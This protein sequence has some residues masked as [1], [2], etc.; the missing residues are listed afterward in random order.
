MAE[1]LGPG[2]NIRLYESPAGFDIPGLIADLPF[3]IREHGPSIVCRLFPEISRD[4][5]VRLQYAPDNF[6]YILV[7]GKL[8]AAED[9][10]IGKLADAQT[11]VDPR[12]PERGASAH[13]V[14]GRI[15]EHLADEQTSP[16]GTILLW[17]SPKEDFSPHA[18]FNVGVIGRDKFSRRRLSV[19]AYMND[20]S[21]PQ[22]LSLVKDMSGAKIDPNAHPRLVS[23]MLFSGQTADFVQ[24]C[25]RVLGPNA[26]L[27]GIPI[28]TLYGPKSLAVWEK[29]RLSV[30]DGQQKLTQLVENAQGR[31]EQ[32]QSGMAQL[33]FGFI[34]STLSAFEIKNIIPSNTSFETHR[35]LQAF[36]ETV[37]GCVGFLGLDSSVSNFATPSVIIGESN[38]VHCPNCNR[39]VHCAIGEPC[40]GCRQIRPC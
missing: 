37:A 25:C 3:F 13:A 28:S 40:P 29:I 16:D 20:F 18:Y 7:D 10:K 35:L 8:V 30:K 19:T 5:L 26:A 17:V 31:F 24:T 23:R 15:R 33:V 22:L 2:L 14:L 39:T 34:E 27:D 9:L 6:D 11:R 4:L 36:A 1:I 21:Q 32:M 12:E 38:S